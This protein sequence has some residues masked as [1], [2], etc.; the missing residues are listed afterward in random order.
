MSNA[1]TD[2]LLA[3]L[4]TQERRVWQALVDGDATADAA[5]LSADFLGVYADGFAGRADHTGQLASGPTILHFDLFEPRARPLGRDHALLS[6]R[7][8]FRRPG[9]STEKMYVSSIWERRDGTW[10][11]IFSQDTPADGA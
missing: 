5:L 1:E 6:Y 8:A 4:I 3:A 9:R 11:N 10:I 2:A 7:A